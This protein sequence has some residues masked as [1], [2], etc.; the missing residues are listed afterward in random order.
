MGL[1]DIFNKFRKIK[2]EDVVEQ[3]IAYSK[4]MED[5]ENSIMT[6]KDEINALYAK[7]KKEKDLQVR[8]MLAQRIAR[9]KKDQT[10]IL[11]R[12]KFLEYN[13]N[14]LENLKTAIDDQQFS[15][16]KKNNPIN[17]LLRNSKDL[18]DFLLKSQS[19]KKELEST[20]INATET[21]DEYASFDDENT[22]IYGTKTETSDI[23]AQFEMDDSFEDEFGDDIAEDKEF[24]K[25]LSNNE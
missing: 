12:I 22:E 11:K 24:G 2:R 9:K 3:I 19:E 23:L 4:E 17:K 5:L 6:N 18:N 15:K 25:E 8:E 7:G 16:E 20:L 13:I 21:F 14:V 1:F 10:V